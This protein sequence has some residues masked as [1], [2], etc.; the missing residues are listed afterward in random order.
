[1]LLEI[2]KHFT[3]G[4][5]NVRGTRDMGQGQKGGRAWNETIKNFAG[6]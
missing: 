3:I 4:S 1:M 5:I 2:D 6:M